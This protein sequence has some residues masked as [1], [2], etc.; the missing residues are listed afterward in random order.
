M[1][2]LSSPEGIDVETSED[3]FAGM[4]ALE[5]KQPSIDENGNVLCKTAA[6]EEFAVLPIN[7]NPDDTSRSP[8]RC[9]SPL[10]Q[11][12]P[13]W[14]AAAAGEQTVSSESV[15]SGGVEVRNENSLAIN[16]TDDGANSLEEL[17][18]YLLGYPLGVFVDGVLV[19]APRITRPITNGVPVIS[20]FD[21]NTARLLAAKLNSGPLPV[22]LAPV[23]GPSPTT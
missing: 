22:P 4:G 14:I 19:A 16:F 8:A 10:K 12:D 11:G 5:F 7:V 15:Q 9:V 20:G 17:T 18:N 3:L 2:L 1:R 13:I 23:R 6:G 21:A